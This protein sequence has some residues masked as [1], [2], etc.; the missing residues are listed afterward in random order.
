VGLAVR[1]VWFERDAAAFEQLK[2]I[3]RARYPR[4]HAFIIDG[5]CRIR[6][7]FAAVERDRYALEIALPTNYPQAAPRSSRPA[8][9]SRARSTAMS[10]ET[11]RSAS[12]CRLRYGYSSVVI[13][14]STA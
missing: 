1:Q 3:L 11:D 5:Q 2:S 6:G 9:A 10:L 12:A 8:G 4:L 7:T 14:A 13:A